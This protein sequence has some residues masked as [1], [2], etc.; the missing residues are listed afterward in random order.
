MRS[1]ATTGLLSQ[2]YH[3]RLLHISNGQMF[4]LFTTKH[5]VKNVNSDFA[6]TLF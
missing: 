6:F 3:Y 2:K 4:L 1:A 5:A